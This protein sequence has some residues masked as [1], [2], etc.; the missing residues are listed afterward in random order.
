MEEQLI[1][2]V[3]AYPV[4]FNVFQKEY[5]DKRLKIEAWRAI[6]SA[7]GIDV[8]ECQKRWKSLRTI[9]KREK[10]RESQQKRSGAAGG[11]ERRPWRFMKAM[12]F[13]GPYLL[14][15]DTGGNMEAEAEGEG[16][17]DAEGE[18]DQEQVGERSQDR[19]TQEKDESVVEDASEENM[20]G[21]SSN[22][23]RKRGAGSTLSP[24]EYRLL[25][26][27]E[28]P[29]KEAGVDDED[30]MFLK[31]IYPALKS[32]EGKIKIKIS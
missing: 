5:R 21:T 3:Q 8:G 2:M 24:F 12:A 26:A 6:A 25:Q 10:N 28:E 14:N 13:L 22:K 23:Y 1:V 27:I 18:G 30:M 31:S 19:E 7:L 9:Y 11:A 4:L 32:Q 17:A 15:K 20:P 16:Q 29:D